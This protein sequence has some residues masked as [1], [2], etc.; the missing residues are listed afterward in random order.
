VLKD[1]VSRFLLAALSIETILQ[2]VTIHRRR[3]KLWAML[4]GL[5]LRG[6]YGATLERIKAQGG[7]KTKLGMAVLMWITY[8]RRP[9]HVDEIRHAIATHIGSNGL[10]SDDV[11]AISTLLGCCQGLVTIDKGTSTIRLIHFTLKEYLGTLP[12][13]F[14]RA[15]SKMAETCLTYLNFRHVKDL[16]GGPSFEPRNTPFLEYSSLY[17][18]THMR[19]ELSDL[20]KNSALE[21][22]NNFDSHISAKLLWDS[23][24]WE[25]AIG[26]TPGRKP[27]SA[28]HC[29][30]YFGIAEVAAI[31]IKMNKWDVNG[32]DDAGMT[33]LIWAARCGHGEL[34]KLLLR[35]KNIQ[36]D[37][38]D[39]NYGRTPLSWAAENGHED[40]VRLFLGLRLANSGNLGRQ[41]GKAPRVAGLLFGRRYI[42][43]D[44]SSKSGRTPLSWAA[45]KGHEGI[46]K[47]LLERRDINPNTSDTIY[48]RTPLLWAAGTG[49]EEI[50]K[51]LLESRNVNPN[52]SSKSGQTPL[53]WAAETGHEG[54]V[55]LLLEM[56]G[57]NPN[58]SSKAGQTPLMLATKNGHDKIVE[59]LQ[60]PPSR[61]T[62]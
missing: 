45:E 30:S 25:F 33:P 36:P 6:A 46:V 44:C 50:V 19:I 48:G 14:D 28:L 4:N 17:W 43:P 55:K 8:S 22:L 38:Q 2:E 37:Q 24:S 40:V 60:A 12:D 51:L 11:P 39:T 23:I 34:V 5:D 3:Q 56:R 32:T 27:F 59:L 54:I 20:A 29:I 15:H 42:N 61:R 58:I 16:S 57:V 9:L 49:H 21:L 13:L 47:L 7:E 41:W 31:L 26:P 1:I 10:N 53:L 18:G 52:I 62:R 35:E